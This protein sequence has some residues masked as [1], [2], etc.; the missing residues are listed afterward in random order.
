MLNTPN[1]TIGNVI[2]LF[3]CIMVIEA[4]KEGRE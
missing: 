2:E 4:N 3:M 1:S